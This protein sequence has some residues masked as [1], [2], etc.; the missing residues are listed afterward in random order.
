VTFPNNKT[1]NHTVTNYNH[2]PQHHTK[3]QHQ[4]NNKNNENS[5]I[6]SSK[7]HQTKTIQN[8]IVDLII[9]LKWVVMKQT[10]INVEL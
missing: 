2:N 9:F 10:Q 7:N 6:T 3:L 5:L 1:T 8:K 4:R